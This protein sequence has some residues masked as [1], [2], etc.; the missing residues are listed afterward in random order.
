MDVVLR[1]PHG[2]A[3]LSV[4]PGQ[5]DVTIGD[6]VERVTGRPPPSVVFVDGRA[7][8]ETTSVGT[9]GLL[10]GSTITTVDES[11]PPPR[12][13]IVQLVQVAGRGGGARRWLTPGRYRIG[14]GRRVSA[15]ELDQAPVDTPMFEIDVAPDGD[16]AV[17]SSEPGVQIDGVDVTAENAT[18]WSA[19]L[20]D[21]GGRVF[22]LRRDD[23]LLAVTGHRFG[24]VGTDGT[25]AFNRPP[26]RAPES[27]PPPLEV[28]DGG[29]TVRATRSFPL[30]AMLAP[31]PIA[32]GMAVMLGS[33]RF[34]LFGLMSP[35]MAGANWLSERRN[36]RREL[37]PS[38]PADSAAVAEFTEMVA[39]RRRDEID[40]RRSAHA[41]LAAVAD[42]AMSAG[43][44]LWQRRPEH[45]DAF[46]VA[47]GLA[48]LDWSPPLSR[49][50]RSL[51]AAT[52]IVD[53]QGPLP[54]VP[55]VADLLH[56]RGVG[57]VGAA[58]FAQDLARGLLLAAAVAHGPADLDIVVLTSPE[59]SEAWEWAKWLPHI[60]P[61]GWPRI[62]VTA[63]Q[64]KGWA[65]AVTSGWERP[66]R[67]TIPSHLTLVVVDEP[68]WWRERTAPLRP[69][70]AD[71]TLPLRFVALTDAAEDVPAVCTTVIAEHTSGEVVVDYLMQRRR[72]DGVRPLLASMTVALDASRRLAPLDDPDVP[73]ASESAL[74]S[75]VPILG[76]LG[77]DRPDARLLASRWTSARHMHPRVPI[78]VGDSGTLFIDLVEDGPHTLIAGT[79][80]A[81]KSE[82]LR[83]LIVGLAAEMPPDEINFVLV[84]FTGGSAFDS[85][86]E[87]PHTVGLV[88]D[89]DEHLAGRVLRCLRAELHHRERVLRAAGVS[90]FDDHQ[91][92]VDAAPLPR[93]VLVVDEFA[94]VAAELPEFVASLVDV[95]QR[96]QSLGLHMVLATQRPAGV[97]DNKIKANTNLR[98]AL[99]VQD[100]GDSIDV[101]GSKDAALLPRRTPGRAYARLGA[102]ELVMF[103][104][105]YSSGAA[106]VDGDPRRAREHLVEVRPFVVGRDLT[107]MENRLVR[108]ASDPTAP[109]G[110]PSDLDHLVT[111]IAAAAADLG[112]SEQR[113]P[114][115]DPLPAVLP[116]D[117]FNRR[118]PGD[119][120]P[121][122]LVDLP[123]E[124]RQVAEWW[125]PGS[126]GSLLVYGRAGAGTSSVLVTLALGMAERYAPDDVHLYCI[127]ADTGVLAPLGALE[128]T[129][130]VVGIDD[131][132][133]IQRVA[134]YL[135]GV[136]THRKALAAQQSPA[137]VRADE[138]VI[139]LM[140][141]NLGSL[142]QRLEDR[143]DLEGTWALIEELIRDGRSLGMCAVVTAKQEGPVPTSVAAQMPERLVMRLGDQTGYANFGLRPGDVPDF[144]AGRAVRP[145]DK[146]ELQIVEPPTNVAERM[147]ELGGDR[148][149]ERPVVRID[150]IPSSVTIADVVH[151]GHSSDR[152]LSV[153]VG[154][155]LRTA[156]PALATVPF[157]E[158]CIVTGSPGTGRSTVLAA[159]AA[160]AQRFVPALATFAVAPRGGPLAELVDADLPTTPDDVGSWVDRVEHH[161]GR[162]LVLVDDADRLGG[163]SLERLAALRDDDL[164]V[165]VAGRNDDLR[166]PNHWVRP[167]L[168]FRH[169]VLLRPVAS[170]GDM[171]RVPLG[172]RL[173]RFAAGH[174][175][176]V[177]D[178]DVSPLLAVS[179]STTGSG[180]GQTR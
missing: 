21:A 5:G 41:D 149:R 2:E 23:P 22:E 84:D 132:E 147:A 77:I 135:S 152:A 119:G 159:F 38:S 140:I 1:T 106:A 11:E 52:A 168:R 91:Q 48:D 156:A 155:D 26:R 116:Y 178:G 27:E 78:G 7:V 8:P 133:R 72:V 112:Q 39:Q 160:A 86:A 44:E 139:V 92:L 124:Q 158:N 157:G 143:R 125:I 89:L 142:R 115:P 93:L 31:L 85:C 166:S 49:T 126:D 34:L 127:D 75:T 110:M 15:V 25:A 164:I 3:E 67:A 81:G 117:E 122:A 102:G 97:V 162:R 13:A 24:G 103:Q 113:R 105:A 128:H 4:G 46:H 95:A 167:L 169:G 180:D 148:A 51:A 90:S 58:D 12:G 165:V 174:G 47:V 134:V 71:A 136:L 55:V 153:P 121:Y 35:V 79:T 76:L 173:P 19:G 141:D 109:G 118:H 129:G 130:A 138:P 146:V 163:P 88:T 64:V 161:R 60:R 29:Q 175:L 43:V 6:L 151:A 73:V 36:R 37:Q 40:R 20:L 108:S 144:V 100:D 65:S 16:V 145:N 111:A 42:L 33:P 80:G 172:A 123:D 179:R 107:P 50:Q 177:V 56:E 61:G 70:F 87:L 170:D 68:M 74:P 101:I 45:P 83:S 30:L 96:G 28:P 17:R 137:A 59:R 10:A 66:S 131:L 98:I 53:A 32:V 14:V 18:S 63:E 171:I 62:F 150:P 114:Y 176:L 57:I 104:S 154:L 69:L 9:S 54:T 120:V 99:R 94:S 82:L